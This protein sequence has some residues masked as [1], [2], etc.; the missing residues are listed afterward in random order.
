MRIFAKKTLRLFWQKHP[1]S[2]QP[3]KIWYKDAKNAKW[4]NFS[5]IKT[6]SRSVSIIGNDRVIFNIKG[7]KYRLV[8]RVDFEWQVM[9]IKFIG[10]HK[11]YDRIKSKFV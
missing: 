5:D 9:L 11:D 7:N 4:R 6:Y 3:L 8:V 1:D 10:L 2:E